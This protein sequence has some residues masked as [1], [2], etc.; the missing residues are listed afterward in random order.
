MRMLAHAVALF[1]GGAR[2]G[3]RSMRLRQRISAPLNPLT[4]TF[5]SWRYAKRNNREDRLPTRPSVRKWLL[6]C[7]KGLHGLRCVF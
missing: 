2:R 6:V 3:M 5:P 4:L 1:S 7:E